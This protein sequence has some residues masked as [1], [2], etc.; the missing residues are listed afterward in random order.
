ML[1]EG[2]AIQRTEMDAYFS[3]GSTQD[4]Y[5]KGTV[6]RRPREY[7]IVIRSLTIKNN[8]LRAGFPSADVRSPHSKIR[9]L[10]NLSG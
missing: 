7:E 10:Q 9:H 4:H 5:G 8:L 3:S 6:Y 1:N 2:Q